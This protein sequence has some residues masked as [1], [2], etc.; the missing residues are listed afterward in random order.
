MPFLKPFGSISAWYWVLFLYI[1]PAS[2]AV[3]A[4]YAHFYQHI[5]L[6]LTHAASA[7]ASNSIP[8]STSIVLTQ[9]ANL[10]LLLAINEALVLRATSDVKV[11]RVFL[12]GLLIADF[13]HLYSVYELGLPIYWRFWAWNA[14]DWGN[15]G[16]VYMVGCARV[17]FLCGVGLGEKR[18]GADL[19]S[20]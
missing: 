15:I 9:L 3:G 16:F 7:P 1:E 11:W 14:I 8:L 2:T 13:G 17:A 19:K 10:Y 4:I 18:V 5:Y 6:T 12:L 20:Q